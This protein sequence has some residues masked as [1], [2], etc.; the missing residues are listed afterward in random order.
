MNDL[1][2]D[3]HKHKFL[4]SEH[5]KQTQTKVLKSS[6]KEITEKSSSKEY[7]I[8]VRNETVSLSPTSKSSSKGGS[9][10]IITSYTKIKK[11]KNS[12]TDNSRYARFY[13]S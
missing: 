9:K 13:E 3:S 10:S 11:S 4:D 12:N 2:K 6:L 1:D 5:D 7:N 8:N